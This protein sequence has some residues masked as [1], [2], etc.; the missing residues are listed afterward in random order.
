MWTLGAQHY[1]Q[2][3][4]PTEFCANMDPRRSFI[5]RI[6]S[7]YM[8]MSLESRLDRLGNSHNIHRMVSAP[9]HLPARC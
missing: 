2:L 4:H 9:A 1:T 3:L 8:D 6:L 5:A 7:T